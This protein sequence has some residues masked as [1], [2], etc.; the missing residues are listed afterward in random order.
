M[1][2]KVKQEQRRTQEWIL[3]MAITIFLGISLWLFIPLPSAEAF[4][5]AGL[6]A[7]IAAYWIPPKPR[8]S[9]LRWILENLFFIIGFYLAF[10]K[11]P[12]LLHRWISYSAALGLSLFVFFSIVYWVLKMLGYERQVN[13]TSWLV[14]SLLWAFYL[15][16]LGSL[17]MDR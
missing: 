1:A 3:Q 9:Y 5:A 14:Q 15:S 11:V 12:T 13:L 16:M 8:E 10:W 2:E 4:L 17:G 6:L 7:A